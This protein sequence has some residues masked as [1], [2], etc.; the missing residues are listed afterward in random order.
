MHRTRLTLAAIVC[1]IVPATLVAAGPTARLDKVH[2]RILA[3]TESHGEAE[4]LI[5]FDEQAELDQRTQ[6]YAA[7]GAV[8]Q[9]ALEQAFGLA[10]T[11]RF[12]LWYLSR[13]E[14]A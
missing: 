13:G 3:E 6:A 4:F 2:P 5:F 8:Y 12:E 11:P 1:W 7:Q 14:V 9:R 10:Y